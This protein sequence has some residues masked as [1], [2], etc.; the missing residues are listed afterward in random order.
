MP[1]CA[2]SHSS[3]SESPFL[4]QTLIHSSK[5]QH[6]HHIFQEVLLIPRLRTFRGPL[7][8]GPSNSCLPH[9]NISL[10]VLTLPHTRN[11]KRVPSFNISHT[12]SLYPV[13]CFQKHPKACKKEDP[14]SRLALNSP[15]LAFFP[16][17]PVT[18]AYLLMVLMP[19]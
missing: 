10:A 17:S 7:P 11:T 1:L 9:L 14:R 3:L 5:A 12:I 15:A 18:F 8:V 4:W 13:K 19:N 2:V 6:S 16:N